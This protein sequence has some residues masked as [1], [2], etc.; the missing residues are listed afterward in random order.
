MPMPPRLGLLLGCGGMAITLLL[1][2]CAA[3]TSTPR[4]VT[5]RQSLA[6]SA[7]TDAPTPV[8]PA[9]LEK[10]VATVQG[11]SI[12]AR[13]YRWHL[14]HC[15]RIVAQ[16][17]LANEEV[18]DPAN[19]WTT[20]I[21]GRTPWEQLRDYALDWAIKFKMEQLLAR[22]QGIQAIKSYPEL[23]ARLLQENNRRAD[24][25]KD[26]IRRP[27]LLNEYDFYFYSQGQTHTEL[28][29]A[30][31]GAELAVT[32]DEV[33]DYYEKNRAQRYVRQPGSRSARA[34]P[35]EEIQDEVRQNL[36]EEKYDAWLEKLR[37]KVVVMTDEKAIEEQ[38]SILDT[39]PPA[40][41]RGAQRTTKPGARPFNK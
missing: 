37:E 20:P 33:L 22:E 21:N 16:D 5:P 34:I 1:A 14:N 11:E 12:S 27:P 8:A 18:P 30:L 17:I 19:F 25:P 31:S 13:E 23:K 4:P 29:Q 35:F 24:L 41:N 9:V 3:S 39:P 6:P 10:Q 7:K 26:A 40:E 2:G 32:E 15:R 28:I 38:K 36:L